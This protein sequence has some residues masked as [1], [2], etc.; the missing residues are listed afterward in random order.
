M[1]P[2]LLIVS[3][4]VLAL[5]EL[6]LL[7]GSYVLPRLL[8]ETME[9]S[10]WLAMPLLGV[11]LMGYALYLL[12]RDNSQPQT[13]RLR[14]AALAIGF[15]IL[16][17]GLAACHPHGFAYLSSPIL[18]P[19]S[20]TY[21]YTAK[22]EGNLWA[23]LRDY[24]TKMPDFGCHAQTQAAGPVLFFGLLGRFYAALPTTV[25]VAET[26]LALNPCI[27][28]DVIAKQ[29]S[30]WWSYDVSALDVCSA[31]FCGWTTILLAALTVFPLYSLGVELV[32]R[33]VGVV[34]VGAYTLFPSLS[35]FAAGIDQVHPLLTVTAGLFVMR[36]LRAHREDTPRASV[37]WALA[38]GVTVAIALFLSLGMLALLVLLALAVVLSVTIQA[39]GGKRLAAVLSLWKPAIALLLPIVA[40]FALLYIV[41]GYNTI[42]VLQTSD[43]LRTHGYNVLWFRPYWRYVW[44]NWIEAAIFAGPMLIAVILGTFWAFRKSVQHP[45]LW[46][47]I[48]ALV[49]LLVLMDVSGKA[50]GETYRIWLFLAPYFA[51]TCAGMTL[52]DEDKVVSLVGVGILT[53]IY[54]FVLRFFIHVW[55]F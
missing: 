18:S 50:R 3:T 45:E 47:L 19:A 13:T 48:L 43:S 33:R 23:L 35:L 36:S 17:G 25:P 15:C 39:S 31:L 5:T 46:A 37:A 40:F 1:R 21:Y 24:H 30:K 7:I 41:A 52:A 29:L 27:S 55:G 51:L 53:V 11:G 12:W 34:A 49:I 4:A 20:N 2:W 42:S 54:L 8:R 32:G 9:L 6:F 26:L 16:A 28:P 14:L 22:Q 10:G 38:A 44:L